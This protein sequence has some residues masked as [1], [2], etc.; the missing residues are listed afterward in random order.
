RQE[1]QDTADRVERERLSDVAQ[2][3]AAEHQPE[4]E[5]RGTGTHAPD[6][7][8]TRQRVVGDAHQEEAGESENLR[9]SVDLAMRNRD[10]AASGDAQ[11][12]DHSRGRAESE[13]QKQRTEEE[14]RRKRGGR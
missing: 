13:R 11:E 2:N 6:T 10:V 3:D 12:V 5:P 7:E 1:R 14:V 8:D 9:M 4:R